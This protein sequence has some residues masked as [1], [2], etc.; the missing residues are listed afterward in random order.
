MPAITI[1]PVTCSDCGDPVSEV[2]STVDGADICTDCASENY[3]SCD[4]CGDYASS[5]ETTV[6]GNEICD[7]CARRYFTG[8]DRCAQMSPDRD[9]ET[10]ADG[11]NVCLSCASE[12]YW[13]CEGCDELIDC[14]DY[15][16][17]CEENLP[18]SSDLIYNYSYKP[19]PKFHGTGPLFLGLELEINTSGGYLTDCA[20]TAMSSLSSLGYLKEDCSIDHGFE[21]VTHPMS[22]DWAMDHFPWD[23]LGRLEREGCDADGN[24]LHVHIS[25]AAF[26]SPCHVYRW[27][28][29]FYR[30]ADE[31]TT[32]A[33]RVSDQWAAFD[34]TARKHV[35]DYAKGAKGARYQAINT[36]NNDTFE[37]R[38]FASS[39]NPQEVKAAL[40]LAAASVEYTR[41]LTV[42]DIARNRA[43]EWMP[44]VAWLND[45][46]GY[47]PLS[48]ELEDLSC[49]C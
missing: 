34:A 31:V 23:M 6:D 28:K 45:H 33:R 3:T 42:S 36:Q 13:R 9:T 14:G 22:Y 26:T 39:L 4:R 21:I 25:R 44:F 2:R 35:K 49:V 18:E 47:E 1:D 19:E 37:L 15:C 10:A 16:S 12:A 48:R 27:M 32:V 11:S 46:P 24:G 5:T 41:D 40:G 8:C 7:R 38:V 43:W 17:W 29:L 20:E 30:N